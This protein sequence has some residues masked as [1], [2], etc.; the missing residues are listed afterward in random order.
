M[1]LYDLAEQ[2]LDTGV[3][4]GSFGE[5]EQN[6]RRF[7]MLL[8]IGNADQLAGGELLTSVQNRMAL[9][10]RN[11]DSGMGMPGAVSDR[12]LTFLKDAQIGMNR[13][14]EGNRQMLQAFRL[15]EQRKLEIA[16]LADAYV[17]QHGQLDVGFNKIVK[18]YAAEN[19]LFPLSANRPAGSTN[20]PTSMSDDELLRALQGGE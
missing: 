18:R 8:G 16:Q 13:T 1:S 14:P 12:D 2:A 7:G 20:D 17:E 5:H 10:M 11:P 9:I 3:R 19:P 6:M 15:L 4:T